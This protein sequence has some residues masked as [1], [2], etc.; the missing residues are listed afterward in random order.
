MT[1]ETVC[2]AIARIGATITGIT[3]AF[4]EPPAIIDTAQMPALYTFIGRSNDRDN[5]LGSEYAIETRVYRIQVAVL[6]KGQSSR[7]AA[8]ETIRSLLS[9]VK[10]VFRNRPSLA[11]TSDAGVRGGVDNVQWAR[12]IGDS[13]P[14]SLTEY[15]GMYIGFEVYLEVTEYVEKAIVDY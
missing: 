5:D 3:K 2:T 12:V 13:G 15:Q 4:E 14:V 11:H 7:V 10:E 9:T 6:P 1:I 8:E